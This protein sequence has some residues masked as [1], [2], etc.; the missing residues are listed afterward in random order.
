MPTPSHSWYLVQLK[1]N[2]FKLAQRNLQR[3]N[4]ETFAPLQEITKRRANRFVTDLQLL[5][6]GYMFVHFDSVGSAWRKINNTL[7]VSRL[8]N[9]GN[10][11]CPV[12]DA[13]IT[14]LMQRCDENGQI[15]ADA[16]CVGDQV[17]LSQ[18]PFANFIATIDKI[19]AQK[20]VW[21]LMDVM[22]QPTQVQVTSEQIETIV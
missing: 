13:L 15:Q 11:P 17:K 4:F 22:G 8:I 1:P 9:F 2:G 10:R 14:G 19:D 16:L 20:R 6:P 3:Q 21:V 5:F 12:P 18:G 7:G